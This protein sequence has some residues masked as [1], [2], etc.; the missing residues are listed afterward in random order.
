M[1]RAPGSRVLCSLA[2]VTLLAGCTPTIIDYGPSPTG[3]ASGFPCPPFERAASALPA[4]EVRSGRVRIGKVSYPTAPAPYSAPSDGEYI[5]FGNLIASQHAP[6]EQATA[7]SMGWDSVVALARLS[8][9]DGAW[10]AQRAS[11]VVGQCSLSVT[12]RGID[13]H[14]R[15]RR[16]EALTV[17]GHPGWIRVT[18]LSFT[19]PGIRA[20]SEVQTV[21]VV[22]VG[23]E[24]YAYLSYLPDTAQHLKA[25]LDATREGLRVD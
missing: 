20:T 19:V 4:P 13:Y 3:A 18:D 9:V 14:P 11:E 21:V 17:D 15:L 5:A 16:D 2:L 23:D 10:G 22:Q 12:W 6:I 8:S 25:Q 7:S 24:S 1:R